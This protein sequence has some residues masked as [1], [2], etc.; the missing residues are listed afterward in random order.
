M[1]PETTV[2]RVF[3][4]RWQAPNTY[5]RSDLAGGAVATLFFL[6]DARYHLNIAKYVDSKRYFRHY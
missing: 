2:G 3:A 6:T 1:R 4:L 5:D